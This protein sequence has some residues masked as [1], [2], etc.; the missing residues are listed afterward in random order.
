M[1]KAVYKYI[2]NIPPVT[3]K[4]SQQIVYSQKAKRYFIVPSAAYK[5][6]EK[7][8]VQQLGKTPCVS[9]DYPVEIAC[10]FYMATRRKVDLTN[11]LEAADDVLVA[12]KIIAD[13]NHTI[14]AS[15]DG[16]RVLYDKDNPRTEIEIYP[17]G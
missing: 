9:I 14:I 12:A 8:A 5:K 4:N 16:S 3:K 15:H 17:C 6:Y 13:D 7:L 2:I 11:L 1:D 10:K